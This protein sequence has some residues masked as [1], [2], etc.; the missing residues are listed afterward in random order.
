MSN[1]PHTEATWEDIKEV[2]RRHPVKTVLILP[3]ASVALAMQHLLYLATLPFVVANR[4][5]SNI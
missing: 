1:R 3:V 4:C 5:I 2:F